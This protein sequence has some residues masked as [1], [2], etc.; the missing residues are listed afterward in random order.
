MKRLL[1]ILLL[2]LP[3]IAVVGQVSGVYSTTDVTETSADTYTAS[4]APLT[5]TSYT[6]KRFTVQ[7][8][9]DND[10][11]ATLNINSLGAKPIINPNG[12][13]LEDDDILAD[14]YY[15]LVYDGTS[16]QMIG[17]RMD[18][19]WGD[20]EGTL[21]NQTDLQTAFNAKASLSG[22]TFTGKLNITPTA[23]DAPLNLGSRLSSPSNLVAGDIW[24]DATI[25][26]IRAYVN[27]GVSTLVRNSFQSAGALAWF[28][29]STGGVL[30]STSQLMWDNTFLVT[31]IKTT[32][33]DSGNPGLIVPSG[34]LLSTEVDGAIENDGTHLYWTDESL[35]R[36]Q[37][38]Q[39]DAW[40]TSGTTTFTDDV[41]LSP[42]GKAFS[43]GGVDNEL[44]GSWYINEL[45][46]YSYL[47]GGHTIFGGASTIFQHGNNYNNELRV[48]LS[49]A[50][51]KNGT[52]IYTGTSSQELRFSVD[53]DG[54]ILMN[55]PGTD[56]PGD[57][58]YRGVDGFLDKLPLGSEGQ[59]LSSVSGLPAWTT[60]IADAITNGVTTSAPNQDQ[61]FDALALK[62][63]IT[64]TS[65]TGTAVAFDTNRSYCSTA[66]PCTGNITFTST[67]AVVGQMATMVHNDSSEPTFGTEF[68]KLSGTYAPNEDNYIMFFLRES[69]KVWVT[70][71]QEQ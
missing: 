36:H 21:S 10:G 17:G 22:A 65:S 60:V 31:R 2:I 35:T 66:S 61:V 68:I 47:Y 20:I 28:S 42:N 52:F 7:F 63:T 64:P 71:Y 48:G 8:P 44:F 33:G 15:F 9:D 45:H 69:G 11:P 6:N 39:Q 40:K 59:V 50:G 43:I 49:Q 54:E 4:V 57:I 56:A 27:G 26:A 24:H 58:P 53:Q 51:D 62:Q 3:A 32:A 18:V 1:L 23:N 14:R 30:S 19:A 34:S 5:I 12:D 25:P 16:F 38:D 41:L 67:G 70:I 46:L 29:G 55:L 37:I 13:A